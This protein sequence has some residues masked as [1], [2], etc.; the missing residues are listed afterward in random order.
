MPRSLTGW[1]AGW[2]RTRPP[3][4]ARRRP[5]SF[6][7][8]GRTLTAYATFRR[9]RRLWRR[10]LHD[11]VGPDLPVAVSRPQ[12]GARR[13][14]SCWRCGPVPMSDQVIAR[15]QD[16]DLGSQP[17]HPQLCR[18]GTGGSALSADAATDRHHLRLRRA[19]RRAGRA[20]DRLS[21]AVDR[22]GRPSA[23]ICD[24]QGHG[25][26]PAVLSGHRLRGGAGAGHHGVPAG[27]DRRHGDPDADGRR[28]R[29]C[30][31]R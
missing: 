24:L 17:A 5:L 1:R 12:F 10:R 13:T 28:S 29:P 23:R 22:C 2:P 3:R 8:Q 15:L 18:C 4:S 20:G 14:I 19:D 7:T 27:P 9:R 21:G 26:W 25:L 16:A 6:E 31:W 11:G 30:R